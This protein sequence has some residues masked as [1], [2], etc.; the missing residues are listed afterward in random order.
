MYAVTVVTPVKDPPDVKAFIKGNFTLFC[1]FPLVVIDSGGGEELKQYS[2]IYKKADLPMHSARKLGYGDVHTPYTL[3]LDA[4][5]VL[6]SNFILDALDLLE[7][8]S[9]AVVALDYE[10]LQGHYAFG[11]SLW[12]SHLLKEL[13]DYSSELAMSNT[14]EKIGPNI[15]ARLNNGWC[16]CSYMWKKLLDRGHRLETLHQRAKHLR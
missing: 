14:L 4:D 7:S 15:Y 10:L 3:N 13:Y 11:A 16:E 9:A 12:R 2:L 6:P 1:Q 5:T 8:G